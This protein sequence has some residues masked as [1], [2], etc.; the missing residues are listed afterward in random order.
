MYLCCLL[1]I[2]VVGAGATNIGKFTSLR[3]LCMR[4][5]YVFMCLTYFIFYFVS[6]FMFFYVFIVIYIYF[7]VFM[8]LL[9]FLCLFLVYFIF[10]FI[11]ILC[12]YFNLYLFLFYLFVFILCFLY[13]YFI[14]IYLF[15]LVELGCKV[16]CSKYVLGL[17]NALKLDWSL[18]IACRYK[19]RVFLL[20]ADQRS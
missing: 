6:Y 20:N 3:I 18:F 2:V 15:I 5:L 10:Y 14:F 7:M 8:F 11:F 19:H 13:F 9:Y 12:F 1:H 17:I 16:P 4:H